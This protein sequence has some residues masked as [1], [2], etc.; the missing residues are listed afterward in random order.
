[1]SV[2]SCRW[3]CFSVGDACASVESRLCISTQTENN[4]NTSPYMQAAGSA[5]EQEE[6]LEDDGPYG[7]TD[8]ND[9][10]TES[11]QQENDEGNGKKRQRARVEVWK[12]HSSY[13]SL[14]VCMQA[15]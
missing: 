12:C 13:P 14:T 1:M 2:Q 6:D 3:N 4:I 10:G 11:P 9:S 8:L 5:S 15:R 7:D